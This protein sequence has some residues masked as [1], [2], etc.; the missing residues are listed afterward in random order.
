VGEFTPG[1]WRQI[2]VK[3]DKRQ[4]DRGGEQAVRRVDE[5]PEDRF[6]SK[7]DKLQR[8]DE[9]PPGV[10]ED[11]QV[12][13]ATKRKAAAGRQDGRPPR[14]QGLISRIMPLEDM[15]YLEEGARST[16]CSTRRVPSRMNV[17][18]FSKPTWLGRGGSRQED[19][20]HAGGAREASTAQIKKQLKEIYGDKAYKAEIADLDEEQTIELARNLSKGVPF[21]SPVFD[22]A[23][24][25][26]IVEMLEMP[27]STLRASHPGRWPHRRA[28]RSQVTAAT[29]TC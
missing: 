13:V 11:G 29:S 28:V 7:V 8:G 23:H 9:L 15:P 12:F 14:Q 1:Q 18:R 5:A 22:G 19:R 24:E 4:G 16:S 20:R 27:A 6:D 2:A 26:D 3:T 21:A 10:D 25:K 17:A